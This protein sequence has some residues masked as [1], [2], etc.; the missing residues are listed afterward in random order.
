[1]GITFK[2]G[3]KASISRV[4]LQDDVEEFSRLSLDINPIHLDE[5]YAAESIFGAPIVH[6]MLVSSLFSGLLGLK[7]P[8]EGTIYLGQSLKFLEPV[9]I[10]QEVTAMVTVIDIRAD[11]PIA[12]LSTV[13]KNSESKVVIEGEAVVKFVHELVDGSRQS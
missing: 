7:L 1:M 3:D 9:Y 4:F 5:A 13:C 2:L 8:G 10:G 11:K 6:G 12:K